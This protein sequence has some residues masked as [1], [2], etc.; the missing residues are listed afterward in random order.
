MDGVIANF[1]AEPHALKRF[2]VEKGFFKTLAP[3]SANLNAL[4]LLNQLKNVRVFILSASPNRQADNDK[5]DWLKTY[6][7]EITSDQIII[8]RNGKKKVNYMKTAD[9]ILLDDYSK[10]LQEWTEG[11]LLNQ[12][13][14]IEQDGDIMKV[15]KMTF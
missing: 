9:G 15:F 8:M 6:A 3:M 4:R 10:N 12:A 13:V 2:A 11:N 5:R 1:N 7:P 14:K